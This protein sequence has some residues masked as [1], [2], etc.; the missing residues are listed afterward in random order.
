M[1]VQKAQIAKY[2]LASSNKAAILLRHT[3][4]FQKMSSVSMPAEHKICNYISEL[5]RY[6]KSSSGNGSTDVAILQNGTSHTASTENI[7]SHMVP[8]HHRMPVSSRS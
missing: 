4:E 3:K 8:N 2:A 7:T 1:P 6:V 5:K